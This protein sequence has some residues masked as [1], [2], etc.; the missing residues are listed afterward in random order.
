MFECLPRKS[1][2]TALLLS[3]PLLVEVSL[4]E[5]CLICPVAKCPQQKGVVN[6]KKNQENKRLLQISLYSVCTIAC[7]VA[8]PRPSLQR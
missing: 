2:V 7:I 6:M 3:L 1:T 8:L 4:I 5:C